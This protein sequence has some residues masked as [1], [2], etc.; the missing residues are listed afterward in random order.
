M[1]HTKNSSFAFQVLF[2]NRFQIVLEYA[3]PHLPL[4]FTP[5]LPLMC[6]QKLLEQLVGE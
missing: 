4:L 6:L 1:Q 2:V 3:E 5:V